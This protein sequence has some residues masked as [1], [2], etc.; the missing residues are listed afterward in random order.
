M[1]ILNAVICYLFHRREWFEVGL[2]SRCGQHECGRCARM[3]IAWPSS[4]DSADLPSY[5]RA[6]YNF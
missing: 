3:W 2:G 5:M 1:N 6:P 4:D